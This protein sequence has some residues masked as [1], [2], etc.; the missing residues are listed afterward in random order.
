M[1]SNSMHSKSSLQAAFDAV[2]ERQAGL[3]LDFNTPLSDVHITQSLRGR[4]LLCTGGSSGFGAAFVTAFAKSAEDTA[5][6][7]ADLDVEKGIALQDALKAEGCAVKF[8][9]TD[10]TDWE[11]QVN[12]FRAALAWLSEIS[13]GRS[14]DHVICSAGVLGGSLDIEPS[15]PAELDYKN[16]QPK[17]PSAKGI[18]TGLTGSMYTAQLALKYGMSLHVGHDTALADKSLLLLGSLASYSGIALQSDYTASKWG[19]RGLFRSLLNDE[20]S[21]SCQVR[22]NML[23]PFFTAT[24]LIPAQMLLY[25]KAKGVKFARIEDVEAAAMRILVDKRIHGRAVSV[26]VSG[27]FDLQDDWSGAYGA[28]VLE[29]GIVQGNLS[30]PLVQVSQPRSRD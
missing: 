6:I 1:T 20:T 30:M 28:T 24:P 10:V 12:L 2:K 18:A 11:S 14:I 23:A 17:P 15:H 5:V 4:T 29:G 19:V 16:L 22:I 3:T 8:I 7:L 27:P 25:L 13:P 9:R 26:D 21:A